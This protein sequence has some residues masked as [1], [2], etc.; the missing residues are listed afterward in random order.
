MEMAV[1]ERLKKLFDE[2][3]KIQF[4]KLRSDPLGNPGLLLKLTGSQTGC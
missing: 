2:K 4:M 3:L 1:L